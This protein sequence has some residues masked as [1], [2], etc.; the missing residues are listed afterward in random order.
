MQLGATR[1]AWRVVDHDGVI[2]GRCVSD[3]DSGLGAGRVDYSALVDSTG[4]Q[5]A[6]FLLKR[7]A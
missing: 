6:S 1:I 3:A 7:K 5:L 2:L 4:A